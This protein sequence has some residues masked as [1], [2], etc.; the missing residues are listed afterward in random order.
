M[1]KLRDCWYTYITVFV[2]I[3]CQSIKTFR[4]N[5]TLQT[6]LSMTDMNVKNRKMC[7]SFYLYN[8]NKFNKTKKKRH[9]NRNLCN[10]MKFT[11][12]VN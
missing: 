5:F 1:D 3:K 7:E 12:D 8:D 10:E 11:K 6:S 4:I 9:F 2:Y